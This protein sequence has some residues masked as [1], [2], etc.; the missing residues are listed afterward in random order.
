MCISVIYTLASY[1]HYTTAY[2]CMCYTDII[3]GRVRITS[4]YQKFVV[5]MDKEHI[6]YKTLNPH[7]ILKRVRLGNFEIKNSH[8]I[9]YVISH[10]YSHV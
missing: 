1:V 7:P 10:Y 2:I 4:Y 5:R 8:G 6:I 3:E 9:L